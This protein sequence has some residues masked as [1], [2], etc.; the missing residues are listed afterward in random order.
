[1]SSRVPEPPAEERPPL[2]RDPSMWGMTVTQFLGA[3][4]DNLFKQLVLLLC[5]DVSLR[6]GDDQQGTALAIFAIPFVLFSGFAGYLA[7]R[8]SKRSIV[9]LC[10]VLEIVIMLLGMAAFAAGGFAPEQQLFYVFVV[11]AC[12][13]TQSAFFGPS[14]YGILPELFRERD[15]PQVNGTIQMTTFLAIIFGMA[16]AGYA[17]DWLGDRLWI[18]SSFCVAI[19]VVGTL[20]SLFVRRTPV[21]HPKLE[22]QISSLAIN[23]K[24]WRMLRGDRQLFGVL[25][26]SSLF[27]FVG[28]V[29]QSA[30][31]AYGKLQLGY[32]DGRTS[33]L[34]A[35]MGVGIA[36][37]CI[38]AGKVSKKRVNPRLVTV[39][40]A[41]IAICLFAVTWIGPREMISA[42]SAAETVPE[43]LW[44][45]M[46]PKSQD[47]WLARMALTGLGCFAGFFVVPLAVFMQARP[48]EDQK[49]RMIGAM[50]LVNWIGIVLAAFFYQAAVR[51]LERLGQPVSWMFLLLAMCMLPIALF[52][53]PPTAELSE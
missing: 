3:F 12:M 46:V 45:L 2:S 26:I 30:V 20:T 37:G 44:Q 43:S 23:A 1:M 18:I 38:L 17:K 22:F 24:T 48:P 19:A 16:L 15:L 25:L 33:L 8:T 11:L 14:K 7:D 39:G 47:E 42:A 52:Y 32:S 21:A 28:G 27:W 34:A 5:V 4:N 10:K 41:G 31:N 51:M 53:R 9:V 49:G 40:A 36:A 13:S 29:V 6:G 35:C 50:N